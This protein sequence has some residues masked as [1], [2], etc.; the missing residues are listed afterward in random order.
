MDTRGSMDGQCM[1]SPPR[2]GFFGKALSLLLISACESRPVVVYLDVSLFNYTD[3]RVYEVRI[4]GTNLMSAA[5][6]G[7]YGENSVLMMQ[8]FSLGPQRVSW[9]L[10]GPK[11][12]PRNGE[13]VIARNVPLLSALPEKAKWLGLHIYPDDTVEIKVSEGQS[14]DLQTERGR[15]IIEDQ[16]AK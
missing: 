13:L 3:R 14:R 7:F 10:D 1:A 16:E 2:R 9:R 15:R 12:T 11:G 8:P 6:H 5:P 4:N